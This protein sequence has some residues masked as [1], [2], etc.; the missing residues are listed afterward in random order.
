M[1]TVPRGAHPTVIQ[2][3]SVVP[4]VSTDTSTG[5]SSRVSR[6]NILFGAFVTAYGF[7]FVGQSVGQAAL[8]VA[9]GLVTLLSGVAGT[10]WAADRFDLSPTRQRRLRTG[11]AVAAIVLLAVFFVVY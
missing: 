9:I 5:G 11:F 4:D 2:P 7:L 8:V 6:L 1:L 3:L 10:A